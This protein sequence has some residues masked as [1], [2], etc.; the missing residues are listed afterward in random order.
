MKVS[1]IIPSYN[2]EEFLPNLLTSIQRQEFDDLEVIIADA[3]STDKTVEIAESYGCKVVPGGL[4]SVGRNNGAKVARGEL[5]LFLDADSVLTN[6]YISSAVEEFEL[7]NLGIA[8]TQIVPLEKSFINQLTHEFANYMTKQI[9]EI[10]PHG[11]GCY[12]IL[13]YKSLHEK[14]NGFDETLDFGE[15]TDYIERIGKISRFKVLE[16]PRLLISTRRLEEEGLKDITLK[17]AKSTARQMVGSKVS[18]EELDYSFEHGVH[19]KKNRIFYSLCGEGLGHAIRSAV[20]IEYLINEGY[21]LIVFAS[22]RAYKYLSNKFENV[23]E[24]SGFNTVY[25]DNEARYKKTFV[26]N[27]KDVPS[28]LKNNINKMYKLAKKFKPDLIISDFEFYANLLSHILSIPLLSIDNMHVITEAKY[29][30]PTK[31]AKD[32]L[33]AEAVVHAFIQRADRTLIYSYFYPPLKNENTTMYVHPI[34]RDEI[35]ALTPTVKDYILVYQ[36]SDSNSQLIKLLKE[37]SDKKFIVYGFHKDERDGNVLFRSF[38]EKQLF[39]DFKDAKCVI[40]NGGF[41]LITEALQLEKPVLSIP[42]NK[43]YEQILNAM[44]VDRLGYGEHHDSVNQVILDNFLEKVEVYR[45]NIQ[46]KYDKHHDN[47]ETLETL[48]STIEELFY[49]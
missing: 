3:N 36:T 35:Y 48:K 23:Y 4:P 6:N 9:S 12:G 24:I 2:E 40:T 22:D 10:K 17:Y 27:M 5:L 8:I 46:E 29:D 7:H 14:V 31:Y 37:N 25:E 32:K 16:K 26:Y 43:Q 34:I 33:F 13:T 21:D 18:L 49:M 45:K 1:I 15:D 19:R 20:V 39:K 47:V 44:F 42:V 28:D 38:T 11:A 30:S 41:S